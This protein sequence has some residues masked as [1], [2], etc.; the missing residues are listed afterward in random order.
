MQ[1]RVDY[2]G[3]GVVNAYTDGVDFIRASF[4]ESSTTQTDH[5]A[6]E[7]ENTTST[8]P[9]V[10]EMIVGD[11]GS[12]PASSQ[13]GAGSPD[14]VCL[15]NYIFFPFW[16]THFHGSKTKKEVFSEPNPRGN[17]WK[18]CVEMPNPRINQGFTTKF[19]TCVVLC[20]FP[21]WPSHFR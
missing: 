9:N 15:I 13:H 5:G 8:Q 10:G 18:W 14:S 12:V 17:D 4:V 20:I 3:K 21:P 2:V 16:L 11:V 1:T 19:G 7:Q 6:M